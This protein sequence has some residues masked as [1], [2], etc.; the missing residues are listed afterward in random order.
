MPLKKAKTRTQLLKEINKAVKEAEVA[1]VTDGLEMVKKIIVSK[2]LYIK[3]K[4][5]ING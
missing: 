2:A 4:Y 5:R 1:G 3:W